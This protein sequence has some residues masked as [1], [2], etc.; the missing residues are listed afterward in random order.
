MALHLVTG[1]KG[2]AH[3]TAGDQGAFNAGCVG[4]GEYVFQTGRMFEAE[5]VTGA[6]RL[7]DG[8]LCMQGRHI[9][10]NPTE[11]LDAIISPGTQSMNRNDLIVVRYEKN[12]STGVE[13]ANFAVIQGAS[14][15]GEAVDPA[16]TKGNILSGAVSH[17][18]PMYR[19]KLSGLNIVAV[20][21]LFEVVAPLRDLQNSF[22]KQ[23]LL[24]NGDFNCCQRDETT[25]EVADEVKYSF[26]MWRIHQIKMTL[27]DNGLRVARYSGSVQGYLTQF[28]K[29][30]G[31]AE[32]YTISLKANGQVYSFTTKVTGTIAEKVFDKFKIGLLYQSDTKEIKVNF[33][34][35]TT[36]YVTVKYIDLFEGGMAY[37]HKTEDV[38]TAMMRCRQYVQFNGF[39]SPVMTYN[40]T[41]DKKFAYEF[42][43]PFDKPLSKDATVT[44]C[45]WQYLNH[46]VQWTKGTEFEVMTNSHD[47]CKRIRLPYGAEMFSNGNAVHGTYIVSCEPH[48][49]GD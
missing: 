14:T 17:D 7:Y 24:V 1:Y 42:L 46:L 40:G 27:R 41:T 30:A 45:S 37:P 4:L 34:P 38:A 21:P 20:E 29:V 18:M 13:S 25:W 35:L 33:C 16:Y 2:S 43:L 15:T 3:I 19:V 28:V 31:L 32:M 44:E 23:N 48:P 49:D 9:H 5:I 11:F 36:E 39:T 47:Y 8:S 12:T 22:Y 10:L 6:V 26:D